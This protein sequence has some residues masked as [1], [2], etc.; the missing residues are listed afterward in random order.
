MA[1][2][3]SSVSLD[4]RTP[5]QFRHVAPLTPSEKINQAQFPHRETNGVISVQSAPLADTISDKKLPILA[6]DFV[7][8]LSGL[9]CVSLSQ[10]STRVGM[11]KNLVTNILNLTIQDF[12][13]GWR[14]LAFGRSAL[15]WS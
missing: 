2:F 12:D 1:V 14:F 8:R 11:G 13:Y 15:P 4:I 5:P 9:Y 6:K 3:C 10:G 7:E